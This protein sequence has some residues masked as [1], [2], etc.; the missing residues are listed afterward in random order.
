MLKKNNIF[1]SDLIVMPIKHK[2]L[3]SVHTREAKATS[4]YTSTYE[5]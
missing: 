3:N 4:S 1:V 5:S 2:T